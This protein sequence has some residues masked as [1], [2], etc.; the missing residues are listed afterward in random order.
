M[1]KPSLRFV[2]EQPMWGR[3]I[4]VATCQS[5]MDGDRRLALEIW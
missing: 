3:I 1:V 5:V 4:A 2:I